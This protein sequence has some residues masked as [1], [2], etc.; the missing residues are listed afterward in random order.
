MFWC[1]VYMCRPFC[2]TACSTCDQ[3]SHRSLLC[4]C[5]VLPPLACCHSRHLCID[6]VD[7]C[8]ASCVPSPLPC[9][10]AAAALSIHRACI[11]RSMATQSA[12]SRTEKFSGI[13]SHILLRLSRLAQQME[14]TIW[15]RTRTDE[16]A[17]ERNQ[18][19]VSSSIPSLS[20]V[21]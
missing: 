21:R 17:F 2:V 16:R 14:Q 5:I 15:C 12:S 4:C 1:C 7:P 9:V 3:H 13:P 11:D 10:G 8:I 6:R 20:S 18:M 19:V